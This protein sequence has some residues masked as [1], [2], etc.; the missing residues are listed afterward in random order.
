MIRDEGAPVGY[1]RIRVY[2]VYA[3]KYDGRY[4]AWLTINS[5]I[6]KVPVDSVYSI[7]VLLHKLCTVIFLV[8]LRNLKTWA[9][10]IGNAYL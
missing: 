7:V 5:N 6:T 2:F 10:N 8:E 1:N 9:T 3:A 4:K